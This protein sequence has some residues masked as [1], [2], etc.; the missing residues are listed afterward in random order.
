[1]NPE[2]LKES[3]WGPLE[4]AD[5]HVHFFS[6]G[7]F[8]LLARQAGLDSAAAAC[9]RAAV[10]APPEDP[11]ELAAR[12]VAELDRH[13]VS[14]AVLLASLPGDEESV[15]QAVEAFPGR[16]YGWF[17]LNPVAQDAA[18]RCE[19]WLG[20][21][22]RGVCLL[23]A[24]HGYPL[25][26]PRVEEVL[27]VA[28]QHNAVV[29][30]HCGALSVGI[31]AR[32]GAPS[33]FDMRFSNPVDLHAPALRRPRLRFVIPHFGAGYFREAL[34]TASLCPNVFFDTSSSN[35]WTRF[36]TPPPSLE[37][38]F[39]RALEIAGPE[40]L[41]FG[42][43]SSFF[44]RGWVGAVYERQCEAWRN[45][46]IDAAAARAIFGGNLARLMQTP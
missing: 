35:S 5:S 16:F 30:V 3:P 6:H 14:R 15:A 18:A 12:W 23:P 21:G 10:E 13:K 25:S 11:R 32:V 31:R 37:Q 4:V 8:T 40:R 33:P 29:F 22:L 38:V 17:F 28:E 1:M 20:R 36:L 27:A 2:I 42:T 19:Q 39:E 41:L 44:P 45:V 26:D 24:M 34:M 46:G 43:D 9:A 7:F